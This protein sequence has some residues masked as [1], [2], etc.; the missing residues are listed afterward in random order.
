LPPVAQV[1][2]Q[3]F[4]Q[5]HIF[6]GGERGFEALHFGRDLRQPLLGDEIGAGRHHPLRRRRA[7]CR[8]L[9]ECPGHATF[10][11]NGNARR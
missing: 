5:Q 9:H 1:A 2:L 4:A 10:S 6:L 3:R 8:L 7:F 11:L